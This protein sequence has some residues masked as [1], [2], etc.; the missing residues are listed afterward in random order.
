MSQELSPEQRRE[1]LALLRRELR[2]AYEASLASGADE[3]ALVENVNERRQR[4]Q[5]EET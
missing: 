5:A 3:A 2:L 1:L 4:L